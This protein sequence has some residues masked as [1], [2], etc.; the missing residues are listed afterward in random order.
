MIG[1]PWHPGITGL[2][3]NQFWHRIKLVFM[4]PRLHPPT[5]YV[6]RVPLT[7]V[8]LFTARPASLLL[9]TS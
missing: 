2:Y 9:A 3:E 4:E 1:R 6:R 8:H 5:H 7:R